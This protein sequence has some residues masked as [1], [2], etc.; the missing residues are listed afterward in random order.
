MAS[1]TCNPLID[2]SMSSD[3][4]RS[5]NTKEGPRSEFVPLRSLRTSSSDICRLKSIQRV[6]RRTSLLFRGTHASHLLYITSPVVPPSFTCLEVEPLLIEVRHEHCTESVLGLCIKSKKSQRSLARSSPFLLN[7]LSGHS[8]SSS[9]LR[10]KRRAAALDSLFA[11]LQG[12]TARMPNVDR[13]LYKHEIVS[14]RS[15][16]SRQIAATHLHLQTR[17]P[18]ESSSAGK[19]LL[20]GSLR[21]SGHRL[22]YTADQ[23]TRS[24]ASKSQPQGYHSV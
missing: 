20:P 1:G 15:L 11:K 23:S 13:G 4:E 5:Y 14:T 2:S 12:S 16:Q 17:L 10:Q 24:T 6:S 8:Q 7:L 21:E 9:P 18:R 22:A 19:Q 3:S